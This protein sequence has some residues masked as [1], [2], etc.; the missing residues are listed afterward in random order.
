MESQ[1][2]C[3]KNRDFRTKQ[4]LLETKGNFY[5]IVK[6][7]TH[8]VHAYTQT[9]T[10][11]LFTCIHVDIDICNMPYI[12]IHRHGYT[13]MFIYI[14]ICNIYYIQIYRYIYT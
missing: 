4:S 12:Y 6:K 2:G 3:I 1:A 7:S 14:Y 10:H 9:Y 8:Q 5:M 13:D 11:I